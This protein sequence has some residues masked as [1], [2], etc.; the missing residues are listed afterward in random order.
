MNTAVEDETVGLKGFWAPDG[1][2]IA[3]TMG[4][5]DLFELTCSCGLSGDFSEV[6]GNDLLVAGQTLHSV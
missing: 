2:V 3:I 1:H 4:R 6:W 5:R